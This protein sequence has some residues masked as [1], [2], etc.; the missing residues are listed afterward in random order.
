MKT[1]RNPRLAI[2]LALATVLAGQIAS[3]TVACQPGALALGLL[4]AIETFTSLAAI[5]L[6]WIGL[7]ATHPDRARMI[8]PLVTWLENIDVAGDS[9]PRP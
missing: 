4:I 9:R 8:S 1:L 3:L 5:L 7:R 2:R 6:C